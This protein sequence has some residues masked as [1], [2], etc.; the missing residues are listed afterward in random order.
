[1]R[2]RKLVTTAGLLL[3]VILLFLM[4]CQQIETETT[5]KDNSEVQDY[6]SISG[7][8][9]RA[10]NGKPIAGA[11][12]VVNGPHGGTL[13]AFHAVTDTKGRYTVTNLKPGESGLSVE[14]KGYVTRYYDGPKAHTNRKKP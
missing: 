2:K 1:M 7:R 12:V 3:S 14:A 4:G 6:A 11:N 8:I 10:D 5:I 13:G 9:Y